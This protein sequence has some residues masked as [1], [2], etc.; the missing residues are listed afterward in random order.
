MNSNTLTHSEKSN[1][2]IFYNPE[3]LYQDDNNDTKY[4]D[5]VEFAKAQI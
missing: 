3:H 4:R 5:A 1:A 2:D